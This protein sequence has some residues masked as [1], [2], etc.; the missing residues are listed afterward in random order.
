MRL[1]SIIIIH[2][3]ILYP[4]AVR[5][6]PWYQVT[7]PGGSQ[8]AGGMQ[9]TVAA[10][11]GADMHSFCGAAPYWI[12]GA[13]TESY[14]FSFPV[15]VRQV[16]FEFTAMDPGERVTFLVNGLPYNTL[17]PADIGVYTG[18][19]NQAQ[20]TIWGGG[21]GIY[22][23][24]L[25]Q[26]PVPARGCAVTLSGTIRSVSATSR[27]ISRAGVIFSFYYRGIIP[28][29]ASNAPVCK[30]DTIRLS[31]EP[32]IA[33][34]DYLWTG[35]AGLSFATRN[36]V[37]PAATPA[38]EGVYTLRIITPDG[39]TLT[40]S[41]AVTLLP[42]P[43]VS[44]AYDKPVCSGNDLHLSAIANL[45]GIS[46]SWS[47]PAGFQSQLPGPHIPDIQQVNSGIYTLKGVLG[48][49]M[50]SVYEE[51]TVGTTTVHKDTQTLCA[52]ASFDF[53]GTLL[54]GPGTYRDTFSVPGQCDSVVQLELVV[55][56]APEAKAAIACCGTSFCTGDTISLT[57][58]GAASY[59]WYNAAYRLLY[60]GPRPALPLPGR[61][62]QLYLV[63]IAEN[64][65]SDTAAMQI[66]TQSCCA[67]FIPDAFTPNGDG[68]NDRF[69][70][71]AA[72]GIKDYYITICNRWGQTVYSGNNLYGKWDGRY[73]DSPAEAGVYYY[74]ITG[75]CPGGTKLKR[76]GDVTLIR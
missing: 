55:L 65:C 75:E 11:V 35:P 47:G 66:E 45:P 15:A 9:V 34:A 5:A 50:D 56:P 46:Y 30:G 6:Q 10:D 39:D 74:V 69:G 40:D 2:L 62:N 24:Y 43:E 60:E 27:N 44:I 57:A 76:T 13:T 17:T 22:N 25:G 14:G 33:G 19:C 21:W 52:G 31:G 12:G 53:N 71:E 1:L 72:R 68:R 70:A 38:H 8:P 48:T 32:E 18:T 28:V 42:S 29:A 7:H 20:A 37:I 4:P 61:H 36:P 23:G 16:K 73:K 51:I 59:K 54:T 58:D 63:G 64:G 41:T 3:I 67:L 26:G 49:C